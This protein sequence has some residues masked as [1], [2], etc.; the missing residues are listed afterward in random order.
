MVTNIT[1]TDGYGH[2]GTRAIT[3]HHFDNALRY[4]PADHPGQEWLTPSYVLDPVRAMLGGIDLDPCST[5]ENPTGASQFY[6]PPQDGLAL[7]WDADGIFVNPPY[8]KAREPWVERCMEAGAGG[9]RVVLLMPAHPDTRVF[10]RAVASA[11]G[12]LF[13]QGRVKFGVLRPN[14]RQVAASH[15]SALFGWNVDLA[16][17]RALGIVLT[18]ADNPPG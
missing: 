18:T 17:C 13:L 12:V 2:F 8:G 3:S 7:P 9:L 14:R 10:Q 16:A 4:R 6:A 11:S 15:P 5:A 1:T